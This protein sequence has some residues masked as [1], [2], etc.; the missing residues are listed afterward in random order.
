MNGYAVEVLAV[1]G[2]ILLACLWLLLRGSKPA[3]RP[4]ILREVALIVRSWRAR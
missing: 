2:L 4:A 3:E 1:A